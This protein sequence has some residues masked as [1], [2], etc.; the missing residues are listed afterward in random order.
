MG[1]E[2]FKGVAAQGEPTLNVTRLT[3]AN[4]EYLKPLYVDRIKQHLG[5]RADTVALKE[6]PGKDDHGDIDI[7]IASDEP[8]DLINLATHIGAS[9]IY[10]ENPVICNLAIRSDGRRS[11]RSTVIYRKLGQPSQEATKE[12]YA[13]ID[14]EVIKPVDLEWYTFYGSYGG[15]GGL[16]G[17]IVTGLGFTMSSTRGLCLHLKEW[18][19]VEDLKL[20]LAEKEASIVLSK[21][22]SEVMR[23]LGLCPSRYEQGFET[24]AELYAWLGSCRLL[25]REALKTL[26]YSETRERGNRKRSVFVNFRDSWVPAEI[27]LVLPADSTIDQRLAY[28][29]QKRCEEEQTAVEFFHKQA[30]HA[31]LHSSFDKQ[32]VVAA[33]FHF[34][35]Q[36]VMEASG[37]Q[38]GNKNLARV[39]RGF[40]RHVGAGQDGVPY[41]LPEPVTDELSSSSLT[42][43]LREDRR[44]LS[45]ESA[46]RSYVE[47]NWEVLRKF[48][49]K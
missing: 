32:V 34:F 20:G 19:L 48:G 10:S 17:L 49:K 12:L 13:Q 3:I 27:P 4:Y 1:G 44:G 29:W 41:I 39:M 25:S 31:A 47:G 5:V 18:R 9:G 15:I 45:N 8:I 7:L 35:R 42:G 23:F 28:V 40:K 37:Y 2:A 43:L 22:P 6:A 26:R 38:P 30:D 24:I 14:I 36:V 21:S 11:T 16:I 46:V 33:A